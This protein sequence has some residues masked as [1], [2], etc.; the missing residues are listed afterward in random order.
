[1]NRRQRRAHAL[2]WL[3]LG[4]ALLVGLAFV[5]ANRPPALLP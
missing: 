4:P 1:M 2:I 3:V 5:L